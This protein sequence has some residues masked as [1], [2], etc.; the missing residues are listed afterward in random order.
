LRLR[1]GSITFL[2]A[3]SGIDHEEFVTNAWII[4]PL[5][6]VLSAIE[7][8]HRPPVPSE[9]TRGRPIAPRT[10]FQPGQP[11]VSVLAPLAVPSPGV[12]APQRP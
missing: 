12:G 4:D 3:G 10:S 5:K 2:F 9:P 11:A 6:A 8:Y 1:P 7:G